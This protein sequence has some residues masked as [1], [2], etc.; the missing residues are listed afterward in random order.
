MSKAKRAAWKE[1]T[2]SVDSVHDAA[3]LN[4]VLTSTTSQDVG[5]LRRRDGSMCTSSNDTIHVL[6]EEHFP[7]CEI[8]TEVPYSPKNKKVHLKDYNWINPV[9]VRKA[10]AEFGPHKAP[11]PDGIKPIVLQNL[12]ESAVER[13]S[14]I[15][16]GCIQFEYTPHRWRKSTVSFMAKANKPDKA[17][18]RTYRPLS[19]N[20]FILKALEK[21][22]KFHLED[23]IFPM[24][25]LHRKQYAFQKGKGTDDALS[26]TLN[27]IEKGLLRGQFVIAVFLDI[28]GAFDNI[29]PDAINQAMKDGGIPNY[30]RK[31]YYN[32]LT[33]RE[34]E[35]TIGNS[36]LRAKLNSG[37]PQGAVLSPPIGWNPSMDKL[38]VLID[39]EPVDQAAFADDEAIVA[40]SDDPLLT[41]QQ[42]QRAI[43]KAVTWAEAHGLKFSASKS[44][45][46]IFT[47]KIKYI[48]PPKLRLYGEEVPYVDHV[49]YLGITIDRHLNWDRHIKDKVNSTKRVLLASYK[50]LA[51]SWGPKP[52][53]TLWL[54][55]A[56]L[57][58]RITYGAFVWAHAAAKRTNQ[59]R[60]RS[61]QR[62]ALSLI[63]PVRRSTPNRALEI[64][65]NT[66]P[67]HL[68]IKALALST[69]VRIGANLTWTSNRRIKGHIE[70]AHKELPATLHNAVMDKAPTKRDWW[71]QYDVIIGNGIHADWSP[72]S[73]DWSCFT[74]G[75]LLEGESGAG[76]S[77]FDKAGEITNL[78]EKPE[79]GT[80][81]QCE[82][83][84]IEM[85]ANWLL[86]KEPRNREILFFVDNQAALRAMQAVSS[87]QITVNR[88]RAS[89]KQLSFLNKVSLLW[90]RS[91]RK[92]ADQAAAANEL[93]DAAAKRATTIGPESSITAPLSLA[94]AKNFIK[95]SIWE[96]W[97]KEWNWYPE[98]RQSHYFLDGPSLK[99]NQTIKQ[100]RESVSR[101]IQ[102]ITGHAFMGRHDQ[103]VENGSKEGDGSRA[104]ECR[105]CQQA[106]ETPHHIITQCD[107]LSG[108]R[109]SWFSSHSLS[110]FF[111][112]W[113]IHQI[114]GFMELSDLVDTEVLP[115]DQQ[116]V[117]N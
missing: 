29:H 68:H 89:L 75:S 24:N 88:A 26:H 6:L 87:N 76:A 115:N 108:R 92:N 67:L 20:S 15:F 107:P 56:V 4:K 96:E 111:F 35:C 45:A 102:Y 103:I 12:P 48:P 95:Q 47:T 33:N 114:L 112:N 50:A 19:L 57:R 70:Y 27:A 62:Y 58:P 10:I 11:G 60:L 74:D 1:F 105:F 106:D 42:A 7:R 61:V 3:K 97:R 8:G 81:Y 91:H 78:G 65:Y 85:A 94:G 98:A 71:I 104:A 53:F 37:I 77:I 72:A 69:Y 54:W 30:I 22:I 90:V 36:T 99:F 17:N 113:K 41:Y 2:S 101:L 39:A 84:A 117:E 31:W 73:A 59:T 116:E 9:I 34:C 63:A 13:L 23:E 51:H 109:N 18:P 28:Q 93:A 86:N 83:W 82:V 46:M 80:V 21:I 49:K 25:P 40:A 52:K 14:D 66:A 44:E 32:L 100:G 79:G 55:T 110:T 43:N 5:L 38:I 64:I 16:K